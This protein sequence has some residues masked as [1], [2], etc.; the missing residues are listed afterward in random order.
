MKTWMF[1]CLM[2]FCGQSFAGEYLAKVDQKFSFS[3]NLKGVQIKK[4]L[5]LSFGDYLIFVGDEKSAQKLSHFD[6]VYYV[7]PNVIFTISPIKLDTVNA[8][9]IFPQQWGLKNTGNNSG[10]LFFPGKKGMDVNA[11]GAW[12]IT[13]GDRH[14]KIAVIDTG[15]DYNHKDLSGQVWTNDVEKNGKAGVDDDGNGFI[16]DIHGYNF[17]GNNGNPMDD[18]GHGSHCSGVIGA[19]HNSD[20]ISGVMNN[21]EIVGVKFLDSKGSGTLAAAIQSIDY[22]LKLGVDIMSN[23]WGGGGRTQALYDAI[24][25]ANQKGIIFVAAA[26]NASANNDTTP[27]YPASYENDN[28][29]SVGAM[30]GK[31]VKASFSNYGA[32]KV[33][34]FAPGVNIISSVIGNRY[35]KMS[36][37]SMATPHVAGV[38]GLILSHEPTLSPPE[39]RARLIATSAKV[40]TLSNYSQSK[41]RVDALRALNNTRN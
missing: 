14:I 15:V 4:M 34:V 11:V 24:E 31:G 41:G 22:A 40:S 12:K 35:Q 19:N 26:G 27:S 38:V 37:T 32:K 5:H 10:G 25:A 33:H 13:T 18:H 16:D 30:D 17:V 8:G 3:K 21:L 29:I 9:D 6:G 36:G 39:V 23:S 1:F 20:G 2:I 28:V 7:E